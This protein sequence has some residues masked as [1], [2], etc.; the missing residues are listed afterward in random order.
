MLLYDNREVTLGRLIV[1]SNRVPP[2]EDKAA[3]A[4]GLAVALRAALR[5]R[6]GLWLGW[7]GETARNDEESQ[8][9]RSR[10][11]GNITFSLVDLTKRDLEEYYS[12]FANRALWPLLHY[13]LDLV[14]FDRRD[15][16][17]YFRVNAFFARI[18][19][20]QIEPD[21]VIWVQ[22]Y[23]LIPLA[24]ELRAR[25]VTN[26]IGFFLHIPWP[27]PDVFF[28]M[29]WHRRLL[30]A[31][32][33]Y[34]LVGFQIDY[35]AENFV[36]C[37]AREGLGR[38]TSRGT[39]RSGEREFRIGAFPIGIDT[40]EFAATA[41]EAEQSPLVKRMAVSLKNRKL[42]MGVDRLD[43]SKGIDQRMLAYERYLEQNPKEHGKVVYLQVTPKSRS[44]VPEYA[45]MQREIA[46][47]A[48]RING[49]FSDLDWV[50][51]RYINRTIKRSTLAGLFRIADVGLVTPLRDGMNLIA[52]EFV[53][54]QDPADPGVLI[55]SRFAGA[56]RELEG[57]V[58]VNPY[59]IE[60][61]AGA[62]AGAIEMSREERVERWRGM[63]D[64]LTVNN[65]HHWCECFLDILEA[66]L[67][68]PAFGSQEPHT[69]ETG[70]LGARPDTGGAG[71]AAA[72]RG[73]AHREGPEAAAENSPTSP[74]TITRAASS[75]TVF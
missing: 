17:G 57:A 5:E 20:P 41:V 45:D 32:T 24:A 22:D 63:F 74:A 15:T 33:S 71:Q 44:D 52:K 35:D 54:A 39:F 58:L 31:F 60:S 38:E 53:A 55:L 65:V 46:E 7:S 70:D 27:P 59:D 28:A 69:G 16:S 56:A 62:I 21:D 47:T 10:V 61:T 40:E 19:A 6:G 8:K 14:D 2:P 68:V 49:A 29:P 4:G 75:A 73:R 36:S 25:G 23:H 34:D 42:I 37:L 26:K 64:Q 1:V 50:P 43:Y 11:E 30:E 18:L 3:S 72:G 66:P 13:R 12:G 51:I 9:T 67:N 48:G